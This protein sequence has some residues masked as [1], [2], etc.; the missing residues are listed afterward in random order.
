LENTASQRTKQSARHRTSHTPHATTHSAPESHQLPE[1][2]LILPQ[3]RH[4]MTRRNVSQRNTHRTQC[5][6][7]RNL[8][9]A[10][11]RNY[12]R[13]MT[14]KNTKMLYPRPHNR[15]QHTLLAHPRINTTPQ[16]GQL[17]HQHPPHTATNHRER[18]LDTPSNTKTNPR[19]RPLPTT[20][21]TM[22]PPTQPHGVDIHRWLH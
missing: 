21:N 12:D 16:R 15:R 1:L 8:H 18:P 14:L 20:T 5:H 17:N 6:R 3:K 7:P 13:P 4:P 10:T 19:P 11:T 22:A 2:P 9:G